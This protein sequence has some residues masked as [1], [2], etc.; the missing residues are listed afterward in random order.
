[1]F[2]LASLKR[3]FALVLWVLVTALG[4]YAGVLPVEP[5][6][7]TYMEIA[8]L[9]PVYLVEGLL[10]GT[11]TGLGQ[12]LLLRAMLP[13][14]S[15]WFWMAA[16]GYGLAF[17][18]GVVVAVLIPSIAFP[19][20]GLNFL[21][22]SRPSTITIFLYP[23]SLFWGGFVLGILQWQ[24]LKRALPDPN[25]KKA[26]LWVLTCWLGFGLGILATG[27]AW[28]PQ[29]AGVNRAFMGAVVGLCTGLA[30]LILTRKPKMGSSL[31][32]TPGASS[33]L[34]P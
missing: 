29:E 8:R 18:A 16:A 4:W 10:I 11:V 19:L 27:W 7:R 31:M 1:M 34:N 21:P 25:H 6:A 30:L 26:L 33:N 2:N 23:A 5:G 15:N 14:P 13:R 28:T 17:P 22:L 20:Q 24:A 32:P 9:L 3:P 12:A